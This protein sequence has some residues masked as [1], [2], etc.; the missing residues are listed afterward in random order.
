M[1]SLSISGHTP[2]QPTDTSNGG[3][4]D[5]FKDPVSAGSKDA[6]ELR[7][8]E[9]TGNLDRPS[10]TGVSNEGFAAQYADLEAQATEQSGQEKSDSLLGRLSQGTKSCWETTRRFHDVCKWL[11]LRR[12][13][14]SSDA[15][16]TIKR[17]D[18]LRLEAAE[19]TVQDLGDGS[20]QLSDED[21][22]LLKKTKASIKSWKK[23]KYTYLSRSRR[24]D[25][26]GLGSVNGELANAMMAYSGE[27]ITRHDVNTAWASATAASAFFALYGWYVSDAGLRRC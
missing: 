25:F 11:P 10:D 18:D 7:P 13:E 4:E 2:Q 24:P 27:N 26:R 17:Y 6:L 19:K 16:R 12:Q 9:G 23:D 15:A 20:R 22:Q 5:P 14:K 3:S 8:Y 21:A 1:S